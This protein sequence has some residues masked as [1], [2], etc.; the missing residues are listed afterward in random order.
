MATVAILG[1]G[2]MGESIARQMAA[3]GNEVRGWNRSPKPLDIERAYRVEA[4]PEAACTNASLIFIVTSDYAAASEVLDR[5]AVDGHI[6]GK[7]IVSAPSGS[8]DQAMRFSE[9]IQSAGGK[10]LDCAMMGGPGDIGS[11]RIYLLYAGDGVAF[12][13]A[14]PL[15][16]GLGPN[17]IYV[18]ESVGVAK[19]LDISLLARNYTWLFGYLQSLT[20]A[21]AMGVDAMQFATLATEIVGPLQENV[22]R[23]TQTIVNAQ[24]VSAQHASVDVHQAALARVIEL[25]HSKGLMLSMLEECLVV[26]KQTAAAGY[27]GSD[28]AAAYPALLER[29]AYI[30]QQ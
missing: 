16:L 28:I 22:R 12:E 4:S 20:L 3:M 30:Q 11:E 7:T 23:S 15:L 26:L 14:R 27:G 18:S 9:R 25:S 6:A 17:Q 1:L 5:I 13:N 8:P 2:K 29:S 24:Y 19:A 21:R 10:A